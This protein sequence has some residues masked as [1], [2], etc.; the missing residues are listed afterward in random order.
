MLLLYFFLQ[1]LK[2][3]KHQ[4]ST[5]KIPIPK[6]NVQKHKS[7]A[8]EPTQ[9][10]EK[11]STVT[12]ERTTADEF[13]S[14]LHRNETSSIENHDQTND[15]K[16]T[17]KS[18]KSSDAWFQKSAWRDLVGDSTKSL[19]SLSSSAQPSVSSIL[20]NQPVSENKVAHSTITSEKRK[21]VPNK[22]CSTLTPSEAQ[23]GEE[24]E[25]KRPKQEVRRVVQ[26][27]TVGEVCSFM[28]SAESEK[29]WNKT[30][31]AL[32]GYMKK[33][34]GENSNVSGVRKG[35]PFPGRRFAN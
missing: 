18:G 19:F 32:S 17:E 6:R 25:N 33:K 35:A 21:V 1:E 23:I 3:R 31:K 22:E 11:P 15:Q 28:K 34:S 29:E 13:S 14:L 5:E 8:L 26:K 2:E 24:G 20:S 27:V 4:P 12:T 16:T 9:D 7:K 30:K 10:E